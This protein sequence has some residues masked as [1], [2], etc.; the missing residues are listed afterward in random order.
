MASSADVKKFADQ[1][2]TD[3]TGV[4]KSAVDLVTKLKVTPEDN[5]T[6][7]SLKAGGEKNV[8]NLKTL[9]GAAFDKAYID[10]EVAYHQAGARRRRQDPH[11]ERHECGAEGAAREGPA[12]IRRAP[13]ARQARPG[14]AREVAGRG[15]PVTI[16]AAMNASCRRLV[17]VAAVLGL[18]VSARMGTRFRA[19][20]PDARQRK[21]HTV[22][23]EGTS[24]QPGQLTV[25]AGDTVVWINKDPFPHTATSKA[26]A[27]DSGK[28]RAGQVLEAHDREEGRVRIHLHPAP[29]D[30][31][32]VDGEV[33]RQP[34]PLSRKSASRS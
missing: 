15:S 14:V 16:T 5:P 1:M 21:T 18:V 24:F 20:R 32:A 22:T 27:F 11:P 8:A 26:G 33:S 31:G 9:K 29:H 25:A 19:R 13:R 6:S 7:Q 30:E 4:N 34:R 12:G 10:H 2:I 28:H 3:H 17:C 23:I